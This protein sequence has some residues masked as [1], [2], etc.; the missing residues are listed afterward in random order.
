MEP[1]H[2][3]PQTGMPGLTQRFTSVFNEI[4]EK[5]GARNAFNDVRQATASIC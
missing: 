5:Y 3:R 1:D 2:G 4:E